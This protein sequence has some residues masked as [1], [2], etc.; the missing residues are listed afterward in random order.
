M[1]KH[2]ILL[3]SLISLYCVGQEEDDFDYASEINSSEI[4][5]LNW[6]EHT[7]INLDEVVAYSLKLETDLEKKYYIWLERRVRDVYPFLEKAVTEY[8]QIKD[9]AKQIKNKRQKRRFIRKRQKELADVYEEKLKNMTHSRGQILS[10][11]I[12]RE[13]GKTTY[14]IIKEL[15]GGFNAFLWNTAIG[16]FNIDLKKK[17]DPRL[18]REDLFIEVIVQKGIAR[19]EFNKIELRSERLEK[20]SPI[21]KAFE[22]K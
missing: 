1:K 16:A 7:V 11:L 3:F 13:T 21:I 17:F 15:R 2:I 22:F 14:E 12:Y 10:K 19:E 5:S 20:I 6:D 9:T 4:D 8:Y 18:S